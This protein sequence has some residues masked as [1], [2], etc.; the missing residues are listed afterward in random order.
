MAIQG[1]VMA[2]LTDRS[3]N[4]SNVD[5]TNCDREPIHV[6][7]A[8]QPHGVLIAFD[9]GDDLILQVSENCADFFGMS[10]DSILGN[11]LAQ[12]FGVQQAELIK[13]AFASNDLKAANPVKLM[14][15][16]QDR[17][18]RVNAILHRDKGTAFLE[19]EPAGDLHD[20][21]LRDYHMVQASLSRIDRAASLAELW[22]VVAEDIKEILGYDRVLVYRF[23]RAR[24]GEV[25]EERASLG[26][27]S[28]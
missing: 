19:I 21:P 1:E 28:F 9:E 13:Q 6:P 8:I 15:G 5:L 20:A 17:Q 11:R 2:E 3:I 10:V 18:R 27:E 26:L 14:I 22:A 23:D 25:I 24:N 12:V 4:S 7:G 16:L